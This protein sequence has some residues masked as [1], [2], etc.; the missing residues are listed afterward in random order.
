MGELL[1]QNLTNY[2]QKTTFEQLLNLIMIT[3]DALFNV[4]KKYFHGKKNLSAEI[5]L[6]EANCIV[7]LKIFTLK[8]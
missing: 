6:E 4:G 8:V 7:F 1:F 3:K 5:T 2:N